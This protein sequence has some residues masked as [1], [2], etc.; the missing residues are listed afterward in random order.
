MTENTQLANVSSLNGNTENAQLGKPRTHH[1]EKT[2]DHQGQSNHVDY[3][4]TNGVLHD[5]VTT[6]STISRDQE[7]DV[8]L[9]SLPNMTPTGKLTAII[10]ITYIYEQQI[11]RK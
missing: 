11:N 5:V 7:T 1:S 4:Q 10:T 3:K 6:S 2:S 9:V 8:D